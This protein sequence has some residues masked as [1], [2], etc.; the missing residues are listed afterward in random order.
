MTEK[1]AELFDEKAAPKKVERSGRPRR[2]LD[3][4]LSVTP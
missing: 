2:K 1:I 3:F 4:G